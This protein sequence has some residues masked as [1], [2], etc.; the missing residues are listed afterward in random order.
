MFAA[1][2]AHH[3]CKTA[4]VCGGRGQRR[5]PFAQFG[6]AFALGVCEAL[7]ASR[8]PVIDPTDGHVGARERLW[9]RPL[10][11]RLQVPADGVDVAATAELLDLPGKSGGIG[12]AL[13][14]AVVQVEVVIVDQ[15]G[16]VSSGEEEFRDVGGPWEAVDRAAAEAEIACDG[17]KAVA[18]FDAFVDL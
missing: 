11:V 16:A 10:A 8:D 1:S 13:H 7:G 5:N 14:P 6:E 3:E 2:F 18:M 9:D 4:S 17:P 15:R 12:A